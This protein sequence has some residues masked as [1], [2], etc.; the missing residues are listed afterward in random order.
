[1]TEVAPPRGTPPPAL[2]AGHLLLAAG[3]SWL[4]AASFWSPLVFGGALSGGDWA[5]HHWH[6]YDWVR[7]SLL[8]FGVLPL[9]MADAWITSNF[10]ANAEAPLLGPL[11]PLL[12][13]LS[14]DAFLELLIVAYS[15]AALLGT[16]L[17]VRDLGGSAAVQ[18]V[19]ALLFA[20]G[21]FSVSH[22]AI[23]HAWALGG[24]ALPWLLLLYRRAALGSPAALVAAALLGAAVICAGQHQPF[25]WQNLL[26]G[27]FALTW[28]L[29]VREAFPL[30]CLA[31]LWLA[32]AGLA[33][34][35]LLP[36]WLEFAD[37]APQARTVGLPPSLLPVTLLRP[38]QD[39]HF[40]P[41]GL[42]FEHGAGWWEYAFYVGVP[43]AWLL[44]VGLLSARRVWPLA[45][46][47]TLFAVLALDG[48]GP[49]DPWQWLRD[50]P[51]ARTQRSPSRFLY[52]ALFAWTV[53][54]AVGLERGRR[55]VEA[56][57]PRL[58]AVASAALVILVAVDLFVQSLPWQRGATGLP[59]EARDHRPR[60][61]QV[62][63]AD[64]ARARLVG[65]SPN[66]LR[67]RVEARRPARLVLP[68]RHGPRGL[69]WRVDGARA[70]DSDGRLAIR[71]TP[72]TQEVRLA[73]RPPGLRAGLALSG[74]SGAALIAW[75]VWRRR[76]AP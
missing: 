15:A 62:R 53:A 58:G 28:S 30:W 42:S 20:F 14:T 43:G 39:A 68:L 26:L 66:A 19:A 35:K 36:L 67:Y 18:A 29:R 75:L 17:L 71:V 65:F 41:E 60:P 49:L 32:T 45:L 11:H 69:E 46:V 31:L 34:C 51:L 72:Q 38:G 70:V 54:A 3:A 64:G 55:L 5:T 1:M 73:Y 7:R 9:Y 6:Y 22:V 52:L 74:A 4:V 63:S 44:G 76:N 10:W 37:Y 33:G 24:A 21:G 48:P 13:W 40:A 16:A 8:D 2:P 56:R 50:L 47:G 25:I 12:F 23:G 59:I 57:W 61:L 27:G